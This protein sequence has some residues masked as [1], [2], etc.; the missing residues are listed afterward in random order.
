MEKEN[1]FFKK[2][3]KIIT[4]SLCVVMVSSSLTAC[5]SEPSAFKQDFES[6]GYK[7]VSIYKEYGTKYSDF[8]NF[9]KNH[10]YLAISSENGGTNVLFKGFYQ[11]KSVH[12]GTQDATEAFKTNT[13]KEFA[14][15]C[16]YK[17]YEDMVNN[18]L[19]KCTSNELFNHNNYV[20]Y[21]EKL[22]TGGADLYLGKKF[23]YTFENDEVATSVFNDV[24]GLLSQ[25][26]YDKFDYEQLKDEYGN[27]NENMS[28]P[29]AIVL[30][31]DSQEE[32]VVKKDE[33]VGDTNYNYNIYLKM[34][35]YLLSLD[36][37]CADVLE[38]SKNGDDS[39]TPQF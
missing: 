15:I 9:E 2:I 1:L 27:I 34:E 6:S 24:L 35:E 12:I 3:K 31:I 39:K 8:S 7:K 36:K 26:E 33:L 4:L 14:E 32:N 5:G 29:Y 22:D 23:E 19:F 28:I 18:S 11:M 25:D 21:F 30:G 37:D 38:K 10:G 16:G 13:V 17:D 20:V